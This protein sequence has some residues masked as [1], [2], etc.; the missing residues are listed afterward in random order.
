MEDADAIIS[1]AQKGIKSDDL[2]RLKQNLKNLG[3]V[4][5]NTFKNHGKAASGQFNILT[6]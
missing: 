5:N 2:D 1:Q 4:D 6:R 3:L